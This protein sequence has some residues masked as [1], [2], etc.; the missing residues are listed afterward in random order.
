LGLAAAG[1]QIEREAAS[2][3]AG[4]HRGVGFHHPAQRAAVFF[5]ETTAE[6]FEVANDNIEGVLGKGACQRH[7]CFLV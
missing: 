2:D 6:A 5:V 4:G 7:R 3:L 1:R